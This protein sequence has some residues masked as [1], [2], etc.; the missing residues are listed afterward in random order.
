M[1][2]GQLFRTDVDDAASAANGAKIGPDADGQLGGR[3]D[4]SLL[5]GTFCDTRDRLST[6]MIYSS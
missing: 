6:S 2:R 5:L 1:A 4:I 3:D